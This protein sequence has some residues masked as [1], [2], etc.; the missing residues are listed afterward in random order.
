[1]KHFV[2]FLV[3]A[4]VSWLILDTVTL[5]PMRSQLVWSEMSKNS[6]LKA[7]NGELD[8]QIELENQYTESLLGTNKKLDTFV[9][10]LVTS[11]EAERNLR[12]H[13]LYSYW[14]K[15]RSSFPNSSAGFPASKYRSIPGKLKNVWIS[16][17]KVGADGK[18]WIQKVMLFSYQNPDGDEEILPIEILTSMEEKI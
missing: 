10:S 14:A 4:I 7:F 5:G 1:M 13:E 11:T 17:I 16:G 18:K 12:A 3:G 6:A 15:V 9:V 8:R 2:S